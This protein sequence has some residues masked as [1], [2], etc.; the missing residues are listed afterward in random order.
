[1]TT[2]GQVRR[3]AE[4]LMKIPLVL[5]ISYDLSNLS[6]PLDAGWRGAGFGAQGDT[7]CAKKETVHFVT[8][9]SLPPRHGLPSSPK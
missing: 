6:Y 7:C 4:D 3:F 2:F 9:S 8:S 5:T 1:M